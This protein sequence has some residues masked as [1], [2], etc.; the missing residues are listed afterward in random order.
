MAAGDVVSDLQS[1]AAGAYLTIQPASGVEIVIHNIYHEYDVELSFYDG[2]NE[3]AFDS[4]TGAGAWCNF[5][6]HA[7]NTL[8]FRVKNSD[9]SNARL[10]GYDGVQTK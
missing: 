8:Y 7:T 1:V 3:I 2:T 6:F 10:I 9:T 5:A 4:D